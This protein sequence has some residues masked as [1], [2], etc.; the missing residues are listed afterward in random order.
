[1]G[2]PLRSGEDI[3]TSLLTRM[4]RGVRR[5]VRCLVQTRMMHELDLHTGTCRICHRDWDKL[6]P[7]EKPGRRS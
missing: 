1:M 6:Y 4:I 7:P 3:R 5:R 2:S